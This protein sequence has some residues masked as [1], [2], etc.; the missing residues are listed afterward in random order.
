DGWFDLETGRYFIGDGLSET[1]SVYR[2]SLLF[3]F[4]S[5]WFAFF[6][7]VVG[8]LASIATMLGIGGRLSPLL[9][10]AC[11]LTIHHRAPWLTTPAEMLLAAGLIY[12]VIDPG[13]LAWDWR[14]KRHDQQHRVSANLAVRCIQV[15]SLVWL[16][17][18]IA[19]MLQQQ[20]WWNGS[21]VAMM[22]RQRGGFWGG[23][24]WGV[25]EGSSWFGQ[26]ATVAF[27]A[28]QFVGLIALPKTSTA[29]I[30]YLAMVVL[31]GLIVVFD[32]DWMYALAILAMTSAW[33]P[34][35]AVADTLE[36]Q[37]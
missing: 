7:V 33:L 29:A 13:R 36:N 15:H 26:G 11:L 9:A 27:L 1:G 23:G 3:P 25:I 34:R 30:G 4:P 5:P 35:P 14:P 24:Y 10:W 17:F 6:V 19:S 12:L 31:S 2:W 22:S 21:A 20:V 32:G 16:C 28:L 18:S 8:G 37:Q